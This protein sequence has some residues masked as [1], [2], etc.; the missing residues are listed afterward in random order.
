MLNLTPEEL[1]A[2]K[3]LARSGMATL[4]SLPVGIL[5]AMVL[6]RGRFFGRA[7]LNALVLLPFVLPPVVTGYVLL[8]LFGRKGPLGAVSPTLSASSSPFAG[9]ARR[10]PAPSWASP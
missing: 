3:L 1:T 4:A 6:A 10:L 5:I 9:P 2:I 8:L 7:L